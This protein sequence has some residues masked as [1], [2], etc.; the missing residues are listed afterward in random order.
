MYTYIYR[1]SAALDLRHYASEA[2]VLTAKR[3]VY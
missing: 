2:T 1:C 3:M